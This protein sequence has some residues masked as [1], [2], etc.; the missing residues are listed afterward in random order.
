MATHNIDIVIDTG[1][2]K[3]DLDGVNDSL[4]RTEQSTVAAA[5]ASNELSR[6]H[7]E[8]DK[9]ARKLIQ[10]KI[11]EA[12]RD[13]ALARQIKE[14]TAASLRH[15]EVKKREAT[16]SAELQRLN[17][18]ERGLR[19]TLTRAIKQEER[20]TR[21]LI[22]A[23][24]QLGSVS[25]GS[26]AGGRSGIDSMA[27]SLN[28]AVT[29]GKA[30]IGLAIGS[31]IAQIG[32]EALDTADRMQA[33]RVRIQYTAE[34]QQEANATFAELV[35]ISNTMGTSLEG[36]A[37]TFNRFAPAAQKLG[38]TQQDVLK[39][40]ETLNKIGQISGASAAEVESAMYQMSQS[41]A[42][43]TLK[44]QEYMVVSKTMPGVLDALA[45][46]MGVTRGE[47]NK[48]ASEGRITASDLLNLK[49]G[50][51][52]LDEAFKRLPRSIDQATT[53]L[54]NQLSVSIDIINRKFGITV[55]IAARM[56]EFAGL[57]AQINKKMDGTWDRSDELGVT[58]ASEKRLYDQMQESQKKYEE[59]S[60]V[61]NDLAK[62]NEQRLERINALEKEQ[63][64]LIAKT[65]AEQK[66]SN[67][68][69]PEDPEVKQK[70]TDAKRQVELAKMS[71]EERA[72]AIALDKLGAAA[73]KEQREEAARLAV[74][75]YRLNEG[76]KQGNKETK[77]AE[78]LARQSAK[79]LERD[80]KANAKYVTELQAKV[81]ADKEDLETAKLSIGSKATLGKSTEDLVFQYRHLT[82]MHYMNN[83]AAKTAE[84]QAKLNKNATEEERLEVERL[85]E[86]LERQKIAKQLADQVST[87]QGELQTELASPWEVE[88]QQI[89]DKEAQRLAILE[90][91]RAADLINEQEYQNTK[92]QIIQSANEQRDQ[93]IMNSTA[94]L[95]GQTGEMFG[96]MASLMASWGKDQSGLYKTLFA[97]SKAFAIAEATISLWQNVSK[98]MAY[99]FPQ[100]IPFIAGAMAQGTSIL[101][102]LS[103][104]GAQGFADGGLVRGPGTGRSDSIPA[105]LSDG[106]YVSTARAT[107]R[108]R[109]QLE[110][111][112]NGTYSES[113]GSGNLSVIIE[114]Y[115]NGKVSAQQLD[116][117][118]LRIIIREEAPEAVAD[119][120]NDPYS[121]INSALNS[122]YDMARRV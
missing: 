79:E 63:Q 89:T 69:A 28:S 99:G 5:K 112:N 93:M 33:L 52:E 1:R 38:A 90:E 120:V 106:E 4:N 100:N 46:S 53:S 95:L 86:S 17:N 51:A 24:K 108:Y 87:M 114:N 78:R 54:S 80:R 10:T 45:D 47:L 42:S 107:S 110:A 6:S 85:V 115:G 29:A 12:A 119:A 8:V 83:V 82:N 102:S 105:V 55:A 50:T 37:E 104:V 16:T 40:V 25:G 2:T 23:K 60:R 77:N 21:E 61:R 35:N 96:G 101:G 26:G 39:F 7:E 14:T 19:G 13:A 34:T 22:D 75:L 31:K 116:E 57:V 91:A 18:T 15:L 44:G 3:Q 48:M 70:I 72:K 32:K 67:I 66:K 73:T 30:F 68:Q 58:I 11:N 71:G 41:F 20:A 27:G 118:T 103:S 36:T 74:E 94:M 122:N 9:A 56:D 84:A 92:N 64:Q 65:N 59:G 113:G 121:N 98:A 111:M 43:G 109:P 81:K 76:K 62:L 97:A 117:E 88:Q 49:D